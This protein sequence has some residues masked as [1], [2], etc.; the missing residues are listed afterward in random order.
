MAV[1]KTSYGW[2]AY[3]PIPK[4]LEQVDFCSSQVQWCR[5]GYGKAFAQ[6]LA[7]RQHRPWGCR[8]HQL[9]LLCSL[10]GTLP[11][12]S[13]LAQQA[14]RFLTSIGWTINGTIWKYDLASGKFAFQGYQRPV[15]H[16]LR[17]GWRR[18]QWDEFSKGA[19]RDSHDPKESR[20]SACGSLGIVL[21]PGGFQQKK[22]R[23][24]KHVSMP[25]LP[26]R[27]GRTRAYIQ[28]IIYS[29]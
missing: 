29:I 11:S 25:L 1:S 19:R 15:A 9:V 17:E 21:Q 20:T 10:S 26:P 18:K 2:V 27:Y 12:Y 3:T 8:W 4:E 6:P 28:Y 5:H 16:L 23:A 7:G 14:K 22:R 24:T 13:S